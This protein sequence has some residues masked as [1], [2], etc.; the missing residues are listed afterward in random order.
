MQSLVINKHHGIPYD[1]YIGRGSIWGNPYSH[2]SG[3]K[4]EFKVSSR[5]E[6]IS[7]YFAYI[8]TRPDLLRQLRYLKGEVL[9]C[10]CYPAECHGEILVQMSENYEYWEEYANKLTC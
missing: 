5:H 10:Y 2:M 6:A 9:G 1:V 8:K 3:T 4:A 7:S